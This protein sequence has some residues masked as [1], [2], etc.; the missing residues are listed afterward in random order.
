MDDRRS[1]AVRPDK[2]SL[3]FQP[4]NCSARSVCHSCLSAF[5]ARLINKFS[6]QLLKDIYMD[7]CCANVYTHI[8]LIKSLSVCYSMCHNGSLELRD[9]ESLKHR[10]W[11]LDGV[12][13]KRWLY[14]FKC[15][16]EIPLLK[17]LFFF[18]ITA[19]VLFLCEVPFCCQFIEF[20]NAV[21]ARADQLKPW[22]KAL[23]Y[24]GWAQHS[25]SHLLSLLLFSLC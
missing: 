3:F 19:L 22:Q 24:C 10:C 1:C 15:L 9:C 4:T 14:F 17:S 2:S 7:T 25:S 12:R 11:S 23:F 8:I 20:A 18:R 16:Q 13:I 21:A 5:A 6:Q